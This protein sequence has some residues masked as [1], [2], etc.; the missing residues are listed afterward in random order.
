MK[1]KTPGHMLLVPIGLRAQGGAGAL[2]FHGGSVWL[3]H[4]LQADGQWGAGLGPWLGRAGPCCEPVGLR[5]A[6]SRDMTRRPVLAINL[7]HWTV[8]RQ[9]QSPPDLEG[10]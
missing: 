1:V 8:R 3:W 6:A 9:P 7:H 5:Q 4:A 2:L 10:G